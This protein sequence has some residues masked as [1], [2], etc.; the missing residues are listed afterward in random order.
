MADATGQAINLCYGPNGEPGRSC[1]VA[2]CST[3]AT[4]IT[5]VGCWGLGEGERDGLEELWDAG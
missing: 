3:P 5:R 2:R 1:R 4:T